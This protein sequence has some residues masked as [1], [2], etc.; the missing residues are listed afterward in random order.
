MARHHYLP[1]SLNSMADYA[2][3]L[4]HLN[5]DELL[6]HFNFRYPQTACWQL[7]HLSTQPMSLSL[8]GALSRRR[9]TPVSLLRAAVPLI[10]YG[11]SGRHFVPSSESTLHSRRS[12][13]TRYLFSNCLPTVI[14]TAAW[15]AVG[16][17]SVLARWRTPYEA[18]GRRSPG[19]G[20]RTLA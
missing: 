15:L 5:D 6:T 1:G 19:W 20:P 4:W 11:A 2:S 10:P 16:D 3:H 9:C 18:W 17:R 14:D 13:A 12:P 8:T 7:H